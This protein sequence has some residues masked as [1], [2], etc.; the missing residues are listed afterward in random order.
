MPPLAALCPPTT[1]IDKMRYS[2]FAESKLLAHL[3]EREADAVIH[4]GV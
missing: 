4:L 3:R 2:G 1:V